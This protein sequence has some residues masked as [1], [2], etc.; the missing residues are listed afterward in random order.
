MGG[1]EANF[2]AILNFCKACATVPL[3]VKILLK[4]LKIL[5][6]VG[7][8]S[9]QAY[10]WDLMVFNQCCLGFIAKVCSQADLYSLMH[11]LRPLGEPRQGP[12]PD[13]VM[14]RG[15]AYYDLEIAEGPDG[16]TAELGT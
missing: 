1:A 14:G 2:S 5:E 9:P 3:E 6:K 16:S 8:L 15:Q 11:I 13:M 10:E 12:R 4:L 7:T